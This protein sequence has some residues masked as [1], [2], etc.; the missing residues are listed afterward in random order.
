MERLTTVTVSTEP[1]AGHIFLSPVHIRL[2]PPIGQPQLK[3]RGP[4]AF[5]WAPQWSAL[6]ARKQDGERRLENDS[7]EA[8]G[9]RLGHL[10]ILSDWLVLV[11]RYLWRSQVVGV[12]C[13]G[14]RESGQKHI[15]STC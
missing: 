15:C 1:R 13:S 9:R 12:L 14:V 10:G 7:A 2:C 3:A 11:V 6:W 5:W 4:R 8:D